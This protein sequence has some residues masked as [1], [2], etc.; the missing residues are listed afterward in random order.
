MKQTLELLREPCSSCPYRRDVPAGVWAAE[1]YEKLR[2]YADDAEGN[3][4]Y[5]E[6]LTPFLCHQTHCHGRET[7]C[8]GWLAVEKESIAV[9]LLLILGRVTQEQVDAP[10]SCPLYSTGEEATAAGLQGVSRPSRRARSL[11]AKL[12]RKGTAR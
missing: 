3:V 2:N 8:R 11:M 4:R 5:P 9:R 10:V 12:M 7:L 1:E 6:A